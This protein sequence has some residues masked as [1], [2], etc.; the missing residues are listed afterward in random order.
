MMVALV[1]TTAAHA[2]PRLRAASPSPGVTLQIAPKEIRMNFSEDLIAQ[3][4]G[5]ELTDGR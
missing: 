5:L 1:L 2:H 3:F 4:T